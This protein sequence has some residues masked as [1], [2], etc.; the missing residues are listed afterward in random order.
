MARARTLEHEGRGGRD[1]AKQPHRFLGLFLAPIAGLPVAWLIYVWTHGVSVHWGPIDWVVTTPEW[2]PSLATILFTGLG[3]FVTKVAHGFAAHRE[4]VKQYAL[5]VSVGVMSFFFVFN[6]SAGPSWLLSGAFVVFGWVVAVVWSIA[7]V[8]VARSDRRE[9]DSDDE[10]ES[11]LKKWGISK[12]TRWSSK[13]IHDEVTG[14]PL[15]AE[16]AVK[17]APGEEVTQLQDNLASMESFAGVPRDLAT[18][19]G[20]P[21]RADESTLTLGFTD[22]FKRPAYVKTLTNQGGSIADWTSV[23]DYSNG[24]PGQFTIAGGRRMP[25]S[26]SYALIGAT[27][28]GKTGTETQM[29][30]DWGSR[31]DWTCLYL[32]QAKGLQDIRPL[33]PIIEAAL[34]AE[35]GDAGL[36]AYRLAFKKVKAVMTYRQQVL[37]E[38]AVSAWSPRC[39]DPN[40]DKR[41]TKLG[42]NGKRLLL[43]RMPFFTVH[44]GEAD[45]ILADGRAAEDSVY[46]ASKGLSLGINTGW[47][48]QKP[49][50][51]SMPTNLRSQIGLWFVHGLNDEGDEEFVIPDA[52]RKA[53]ANPG[54]WGQRKPGQ[55]YMLGPG[56]DET[57]FPLALKTRFVVGSPNDENGQPLDFDALNDRYTNEMLRRNMTSA[58]TMLKLDQGSVDAMEGW[59]EEQVERTADLRARML[60]PQTAA[61]QVR[62]AKSAAPSPAKSA[63]AE[64]PEDEEEEAFDPA[65]AAELEGEFHED[66]ANTTE[67]DGYPLYGDDEEEAAEMR[68]I[69]LGRRA[70]SAGMDVDPLAD[71]AEDDKPEA[72]SR[73]DAL[74]KLRRTLK[75]MLTDKK[76]ADSW[77]PGTAVVTPAD[78]YDE[79]PVRSRPWTSGE[80][81]R[82]QTTGGTLEDGVLME[83]IGDPRKGRYRLRA[84]GPTGHVQ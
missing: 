30:T 63:W 7:R 20:N 37:G 6:Q 15:R 55:H 65:E 5:S 8:D 34:I 17:H 53:G 77:E 41:P 58:A 49:D 70:D 16:I 82:L 54:K 33:L 79:C 38:Y 48:L 83:R 29:L 47:S 42:A 71:S 10:H 69:R 44:I 68:A 36:S 67:I 78:V 35:D 73:E 11:L 4:A 57:L 9:G 84:T 52:V 23:A 19:V 39:A 25:T 75:S 61:P 28:A 46:L 43:P 56:I 2:A 72:V 21:D 50:W 12:K 60:T 66:A 1:L 22:P 27:R 81:L 51:K 45:A 31:I 64:E 3:I 13:V 26:T 24:K 40:P 18:A 76:Y 80:L 59:W 32:N 62:P 74:I 14:E